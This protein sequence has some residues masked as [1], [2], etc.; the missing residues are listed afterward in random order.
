MYL[1]HQ[2]I[3]L[4]YFMTRT[5]TVAIDAMGGDHGPSVT[6]PAAL[7][8]LVRFPSLQLV[9]VGDE[10]LL[11]NT[12]RK[13]GGEAESRVRVVHASQVVTMEDTLAVALRSKRDS[14]MRI[15]INLV[16]EQQADA[17]VSAGNTG[18]LMAISRF[19]LKTHPKIDRPAICTA[20]P[21]ITGHCHMLDLGANIDSMAEHLHQFAV[22]GSI[23]ATAVDGMERP[24]VALL[25]IGQ[26]D[27]KGGE[28]IKAAAQ[29]LAA[30]SS[31]NYIGFVEGDGIFKG[32]ADVVVCD[33]FVGNV[34]LKTA[35]GVAK[36]M[37]EIIKQQI[38][39]NL[40]TL[41]SGLLALPILNGLKREM[42]PG[43]YNG[44]SL[45]GLNGIVIKSHGS[46]GVKSFANA[47]GVAVREVDKDVPALIAQHIG[48]VV[49]TA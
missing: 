44:A 47:L 41:L 32:H 48:T 29:L 9:L 2:N 23:L 15:A 4:I 25:N 33:G 43:R 27:I 22:M 37:G 3:C 7:L 46:A 14:S 35:E 18:A 36:M 26:E 28:Q 40:L 8:A 1:R 39:R 31:L 17:C 38:K 24:R 6:V 34:A 16:H 12:L 5:Y 20:L 19:V 13:C 42:D 45:V 21:T 49:A 10:V 30:D 11:R